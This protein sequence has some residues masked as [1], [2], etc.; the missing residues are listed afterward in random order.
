MDI[1]S[2]CRVT[3]DEDMQAFPCKQAYVDREGA[4]RWDLHFLHAEFGRNGHTMQFKPWV[5][6]VTKHVR[7]PSTSEYKFR[8]TFT[9]FFGPCVV[10]QEV[11]PSTLRLLN[12]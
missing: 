12:Y 6:L 10:C 1:G 8:R 4:L 3:V 9:Y 7:L 5:R 11:V 2:L